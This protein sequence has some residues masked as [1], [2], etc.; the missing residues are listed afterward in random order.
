[1]VARLAGTHSAAVLEGREPHPIPGCERCVAVYRDL[2]EIAEAVLPLGDRASRY[3]IRRFDSSLSYDPK[4]RPKPGIDRPDV[5]LTIEIRHREDYFAPIDPCEDRCEHEII[6]GLRS[7][8]VQ[9]GTWSPATAR[10]F[11]QQL[12]ERASPEPR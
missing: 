7:L 6:A 3:E 11:H 8:G 10:Y 12:L 4:R 9:E 1:M 2:D 5:R